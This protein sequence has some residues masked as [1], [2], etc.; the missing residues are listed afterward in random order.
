MK[1]LFNSTASTLL[2]EGRED[3][4]RI[5][6]TNGAPNAKFLSLLLFRFWPWDDGL[7][8]MFFVKLVCLAKSTDKYKTLRSVS[9]YSEKGGAGKKVSFLW[10]GRLWKPLNCC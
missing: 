7:N 9:P 5:S 3:K 2:G 6:E 10:S 4:R 1:S 8:S